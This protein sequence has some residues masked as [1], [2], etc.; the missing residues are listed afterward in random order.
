LASGLALATAFS[1]ATCFVTFK[2]LV[3]VGAFSFVTYFTSDAILA[4][5]STFFSSIAV[6]ALSFTIFYFADS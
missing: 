6:A 5:L 2:S 3:F 4:F 1:S